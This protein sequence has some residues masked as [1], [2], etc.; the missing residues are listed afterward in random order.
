M[1]RLQRKSFA[2]P[3]EVRMFPSG[4]IDVVL[5]DPAHRLRHFG[6]ARGDDDR[7]HAARHRGGRDAYEIP[8]GPRPPGAIPKVWA[9]RGE[10]ELK[11]LTGPR[12][13][14]ALER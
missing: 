10:Y 11:G 7:R 12:T 5:P 3:D 1:P 4:H 2:T 6:K 9:H 8:P 14:Y 13:V